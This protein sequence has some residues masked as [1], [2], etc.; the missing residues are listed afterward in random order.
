[1]G[2]WRG[3]CTGEKTILGPEKRI[4]RILR[5]E[6]GPLMGP[7]DGHCGWRAGNDRVREEW[8]PGHVILSEEFEM[9]LRARGNDWRILSSQVTWIDLHFKRNPSGIS[10]ENK[11]VDGREKDKAEAIAVNS[12]QEW[13]GWREW[14]EVLGS[15]VSIQRMPRRL[16]R[17]KRGFPSRSTY[18]EVRSEDP[19]L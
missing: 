1:M 12:E 10:V 5:P 6:C 16:R 11:L 18:G 7:R 15:P 3:G 8:C 9:I 4:S 17:W 14:G 13:C 2:G 19:S